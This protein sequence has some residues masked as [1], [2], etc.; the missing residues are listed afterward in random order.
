MLVA[1]VLAVVTFEPIW[2]RL[3]SL[4]SPPSDVYKS[5]SKQA[6][7]YLHAQA[8]TVPYGERVSEAI[9]EVMYDLYSSADYKSRSALLLLVLRG[10]V[11]AN[12]L[13]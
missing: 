10:R 1:A 5:K 3:L 11:T 12:S 7:K 13:L 6:P 2:L 8:R 9:Q 4:S